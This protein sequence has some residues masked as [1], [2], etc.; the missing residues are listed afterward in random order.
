M[1]FTSLLAGIA[2][3]I[4]ATGVVS[5]YY[6]LR[7][8]ANHARDYERLYSSYQDRLKA[9]SAVTA[10]METYNAEL[11]KLADK[12][13]QARLDTISTVSKVFL[14]GEAELKAH[15]DIVK[16]AG[17]TGTL[18]HTGFAKQL[19]SSLETIRVNLFAGGLEAIQLKSNESDAGE[20][21]NNTV[22]ETQA[23]EMVAAD[24]EGHY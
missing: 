12:Q 7:A 19:L 3:G 11:K 9:N 18:I 2:F 14:D 5:F 22:T 21:V 15:A 23:P 16:L 8:L 13:L 17:T 6:H 24:E 4:L 20:T 10:A 1:E